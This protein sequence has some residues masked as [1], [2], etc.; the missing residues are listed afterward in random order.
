MTREIKRECS[1]VK[2]VS[3]GLG[4][5]IITGSFFAFFFWSMTK[6]SLSMGMIFFG[7]ICGLI[8][9]VLH[10]RIQG[11]KNIQTKAQGYINEIVAGNYKININESEYL[12]NEISKLTGNYRNFFEQMIESSM[13]SQQILS[14]LIHFIKTNEKTTE[15]VKEHIVLSADK[16]EIYID[17]V[18]KNVQIYNEMNMETQVMLREFEQMCQTISHSEKIFVEMSNTME[19]TEQNY[20]VAYSK[21]E[22]ITENMNKLSESIHKIK[23]IAETIDGIANRT[24]LLALNAAIESARAGEAG[25][26]FSVVADEIR[27]LSTDTTESLQEINEIAGEVILGIQTVTNL[28][29]ESNEVNKLALNRLLDSKEMIKESKTSSQLVNQELIKS[30]QLIQGLSG[31]IENLA[32]NTDR[33]SQDAKMIETYLE[34]S[35]QEIEILAKETSGLNSQMERMEKIS[36]K[37]SKMISEDTMDKLLKRQCELMQE[38]LS[39]QIDEKAYD[40]AVA[41]NHLDA[42]SVLDHRGIIVYNTDKSALNINLFDLYPPYKTFFSSNEKYHLTPIV[43]TI[44]GKNSKF[45]AVKSK[46]RN[47]LII[48]GYVF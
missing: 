23:I 37:T 26:G 27:K 4:I 14:D 16:M 42:L 35:R 48:V 18:E 1:R 20:E 24:N 31:K 43:Q 36:A 25:R 38:N 15:L 41:E 47:Y 29:K 8:A 22:H 40:Q 6:L 5:G 32:E 9:G 13:Q 10:F 46:D 7:V 45:C 12:L 44:D 19:Q 33:T 2:R 30:T 39:H 28:S 3:L 21:S 34:K 11:I 17:E